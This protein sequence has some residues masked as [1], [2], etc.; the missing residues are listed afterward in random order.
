MHGAQGS[1]SGG[2]R[3]NQHA[4]KHGRYT[5]RANRGTPGGPAALAGTAALLGDQGV[6]PGLYDPT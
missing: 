1:G 2:P 3:G 5:V 6:R 4:L